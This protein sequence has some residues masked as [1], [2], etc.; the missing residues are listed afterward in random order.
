MFYSLNHFKSVFANEF[1]VEPGD[2][3]YQLARWAKIHGFH[4]EFYWQS[5]QAIEKYCKAAL[6]LNGESTKHGSHGIENLYNRCCDRFGDLVVQ[7]FERPELFPQE[8]WNDEEPERFLR[9]LY[10]QGNPNSRYGMTSWFNR[11]SDLIKLDILAFNIRRCTI[12]IDWVVGEDFYVEK[13]L[14]VFVGKNFSDV[15][16]AN[17]SYQVRGDFQTISSPAVMSGEDV[18]DSLVL[19]NYQMD[20]A[21]S[22]FSGPLPPSLSAVIGPARNS[23]LHI[24]CNQVSYRQ[25]T[26]PSSLLLDGAAW[27]LETIKLDRQVMEI[28]ELQ[29]KRNNK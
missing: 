28:L 3:N 8:L 22:C 15:L 9:F 13:D 2:Q 7:R 6:V 12:G 1:F 20:S 18:A 27:M 21:P 5:V 10:Q 29:V 17:P 23:L 26:E 25:S 24:L 4:R 11:P 14:Q 16:R 19:W